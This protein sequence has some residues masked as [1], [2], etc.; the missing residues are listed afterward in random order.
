MATSNNS[1]PSK[2]NSTSKV[3]S[4]LSYLQDVKQTFSTWKVFQAALLTIAGY[5]TYK[6]FSCFIYRRFKK[7]PKG[8]F[9]FPFIGSGPSVYTEKFLVNN[10]GLYGAITLCKLF[11][12]KIIVI[13]NSHVA[14]HLILN[15]KEFVNHYNFDT[16]KL[17]RIFNHGSAA[18][19]SFLSANGE[20]WKIRRQYAMVALIRFCDSK[21]MTKIIH[22]VMKNVGFKMLDQACVES[23][24]E[25]ES[26]GIA[27]GVWHPEE[28]CYYFAFN[29]IYHANFG[30]SLDINDKKLL[31][32]RGI[33]ETNSKCLKQLRL[34]FMWDW[35]YDLFKYVLK[36]D[37]VKLFENNANARKELY[38]D[39]INQR[40]EYF[41]SNPKLLDKIINNENNKYQLCY[42]DYLVYLLYFA[43]NDCD[44]TN[45]NKNTNKNEN[46]KENACENTN[47]LYMHNS[48]TRFAKQGLNWNSERVNL[49]Q[50]KVI[51]D[52]TIMFFAGT[53][54]TASTLQYG[55]FILAKSPQ[56]QEKLHNLLKE[57]I[58]NI[59]LRDKAIE[60]KELIDCDEFRAFV[61][62]VLRIS[63]TVPISLTHS[64][65]KD[66]KI[67]INNYNNKNNNNNNNNNNSNEELEYVIPGGCMVSTNIEYIQR[68]E[69]P[70]EHWKNKENG[71]GME[72][73]CLDNWLI[74]D[75]EK[76]KEKDND[77]YKVKFK[78][79]ESF[80]NFGYGMRDCVGQQLAI[81]EIHLIL[82]YLIV[83]YQIKAVNGDVKFK[84]N[85]KFGV[86]ATCDNPEGV[87][88]CKR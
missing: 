87:V 59:T 22:D 26:D 29:T 84:I 81:K 65:E 4:F 17:D 40:R 45:K 51:N 85:R 55:V 46:E 13:N 88:I 7:Y 10:C 20:T 82:G 68:G 25:S 63:S 19:R 12:R 36:R 83:H 56:I 42:I 75:K 8:P 79:N 38:I 44:N 41:E 78:M 37:I 24:S 47:H 80:I 3:D 28:L 27:G 50:L 64:L 30:H 53:D 21:L 58:P 11:D 54:T 67:K 15:K 52:L 6:Y 72:D 86:V 49:N 2:R 57:K 1:N 23:E 48:S 71:L 74:K 31:K 16:G 32:L 66:Y 35:C 70:Y 43:N 18:D 77:I 60:F 76:E 61:Y 33:I 14:K 69:S 34:A 5:S 39:M 73:V 9:W 62:E